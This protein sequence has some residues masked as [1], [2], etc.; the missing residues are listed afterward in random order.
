MKTKRSHIDKTILN[1]KSN[2]GNTTPGFKLYYRAM[3]Q[4]LHGSDTKSDTQTS[5]IQYI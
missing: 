3:E 1:K 2:A 5:G 4:N